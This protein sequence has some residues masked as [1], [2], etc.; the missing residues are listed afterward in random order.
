M[1]YGP[2]YGN[3]H[4]VEDRGGSA[5]CATRDSDKFHRPDMACEYTMLPQEMTSSYGGH[6][7][8][9]CCRSDVTVGGR[10]PGDPAAAA[11]DDEDGGGRWFSCSCR[12]PPP[13]STKPRPP[14]PIAY[15]SGSMDRQPGSWRQLSAPRDDDVDDADAHR[16]C[17]CTSGRCR[18][19]AALSLPRRTYDDP[20]PRRRQLACYVIASA[21]DEEGDDAVAASTAPPD[22]QAVAPSAVLAQH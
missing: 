14:D 17:T 19:S 10:R 7:G 1:R 15:L 12:G 20:D 21:S 8:T 16:H 22:V 5:Y 6:G 11:D 3:G 13:V 4:A 2:S 9:G 18:P